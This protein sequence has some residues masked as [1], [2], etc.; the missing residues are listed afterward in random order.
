MHICVPALRRG[1]Q[2]DQEFQIIL[3]YIAY[4]YARI[5]TIL[6]KRR[7]RVAGEMAQLIKSLT[8]KYGEWILNPQ[9][10]YKH[11]SGMVAPLV[12]ASL[13]GYPVGKL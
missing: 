11:W 6:Y 2:E 4:R 3:G 10:I 8:H 13:I 1:R 5:H 12:T 7:Q 9:S